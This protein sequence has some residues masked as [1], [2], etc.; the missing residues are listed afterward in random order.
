MAL[1]YWLVL[2]G[3]LGLIEVAAP[4]MVSF[5]SSAQRWERLQFCGLR[6]DLLGSTRR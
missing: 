6:Q 2:A 3:I 4:A 1:W 5:G